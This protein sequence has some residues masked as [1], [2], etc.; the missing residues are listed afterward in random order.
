MLFWTLERQ[1]GKR[2]P[3]L[4]EIL[5]NHA[6]ALNQHILYADGGKHDVLFLLKSLDLDMRMGY[7]LGTVFGYGRSDEFKGYSYL[8]LAGDVPRV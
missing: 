1:V 3:R 4:D 2:I 6:H 7:P 8:P 5:E